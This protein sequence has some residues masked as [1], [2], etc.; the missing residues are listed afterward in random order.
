[1]ITFLKNTLLVILA[2]GAFSSHAQQTDTAALS[3][4]IAIYCAAWGESDVPKRT[5]MLKKTWARQG[6]YTDPTAQVEGRDALIVHVG[7]FLEQYPGAQIVVSSAVDTH[8]ERF[9]FG[10]RMVAA[11]GST[12]LEGMDFGEADEKGQIR[13]ITGFFG[14]L[15]PHP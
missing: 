7:K 4:T 9:R 5:Q 3:E 11:D 2:A 8:H 1:M 10:W 14:P 15:G 6:T 12:A 13:R